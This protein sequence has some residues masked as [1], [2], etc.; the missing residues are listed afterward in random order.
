MSIEP[1]LPNDKLAEQLVAYLDGELDA[2]ASRRIEELLATEPKVREQL[3]RLQR[4][5][6]LLDRLPRAEVEPS[7][8]QTTVEMIALAEVAEQQ[9]E[10][11]TLPKRRMGLAAAWMT[12]FAAMTLAG[13]CVTRVMW[14]SPN[15]PLLQDLAVIENLDIYQPTRDLDFLRKISADGLFATD[16][17]LK[18]PGAAALA[19]PA[20]PAAAKRPPAL[21]ADEP[22]A[23]RR[24][25]VA[26]MSPEEKEQLLHKERRFLELAADDQQRLRDLHAALQTDPQAAPWWTVMLRF[27]DW[28]VDLPTPQRGELLRLEGD[29]RVARIKQLQREQASLLSRQLSPQDMDAVV[30]WTEQ[31]ILD[32]MDSVAKRKLEQFSELDRRRHVIYF[33]TQRWKE[34]GPG[35]LPPVTP[36]EVRKLLDMLSPAARQQLQQALDQ[37]Q[38]FQLQQLVAGWVRQSLGQFLAAQVGQ[39]MQL[40]EA[41][42]ERLKKFFE[43]E[44]SKSE[45]ERLLSLPAEVMQRELRRAYMMSR[46]PEGR[47]FRQPMSQP[48]VRPKKQS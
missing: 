12:A 38:K 25:R 37:P 48:Q 21:K 43:E 40:A 39:R 14:P 28:L 31:R 23:A 47:P 6:D 13:F 42:D 3:H 4:S 11:A 46:L 32:K 45:R 34:L 9:E 1:S 19:T 36:D 35:N 22:I 5:W 44:L 20:E 30:R 24:E 10:Q 8:T 2:E 18:S 33:T 15:G 27:H 17:A 41:T 7:F 29:D 16:Q 26:A